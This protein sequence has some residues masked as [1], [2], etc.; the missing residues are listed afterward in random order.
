MFFLVLKEFGDSF[1]V[2]RKSF[3][4]KLTGCFFKDG[5][6]KYCRSHSATSLTSTLAISS[7][8]NATLD[9]ET[10]STSLTR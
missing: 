2:C 1:Q 7:D 4:S 8:D 3:S 6:S 5:R 10:A 9:G